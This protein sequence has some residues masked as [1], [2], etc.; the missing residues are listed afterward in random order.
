MNKANFVIGA[1]VLTFGSMAIANK[2]ASAPVA[3][4]AVVMNDAADT[5]V[6]NVP[7]GWLVCKGLDSDNVTT[8]MKV[9]LSNVTNRGMVLSTRTLD[10][11]NNEDILLSR[12]D[13]DPE[14]ITFGDVQTIKG[15]KVVTNL[16][17]YGTMQETMLATS[18]YSGEDN[19][20]WTFR[21][22]MGDCVKAK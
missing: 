22:Q 6:S 19:S 21:F 12:K 1:L 7:K 17:T 18:V 13:N 5:F 11:Q 9:K 15:S 16:V 20:I 3:Q 14:L 10:N 4:A 8:L 2:I